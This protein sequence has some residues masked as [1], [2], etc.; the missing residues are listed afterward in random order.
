MTEDI[1][2]ADARLALRS[3]EDQ[4][5]QVIAQIDLPRWYWL[6]L[7]GGWVLLGM[8]NDTGNPWIT[9]AATLIFG[10]VHAA[11]A[12]HVF[13]GRH[14]SAQLSVHAAVVGRRLPRM[15]FAWLIG[16][17]LVTIGIAFAV[18]ADG[19]DHASTISA[20]FAATVILCGG[21]RLMASFRDRIA[22]DAA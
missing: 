19:A 13:S 17:T 8:A 21:P 20:V 12:S 2:E 6:G 4:R 14:K 15:L 11:A 9:T 22:K 18:N 1:S 7:A 3:I 16:L 10:A 5:Q